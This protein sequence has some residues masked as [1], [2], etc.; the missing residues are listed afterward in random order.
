MTRSYKL[1]EWLRERNRLQAKARRRAI[2]RDETIRATYQG[3]TPIAKAAHEAGGV[4]IEVRLRLPLGEND[5]CGTPVPVVG[6]NGGKIPCGSL[7]TING[8]T[9][10]YYCG[11]CMTQHDDTSLDQSTPDLNR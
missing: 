9:R 3:N 10:P 4:L 6:T 8:E 7:L 1:P 5:G 11:Y 2:Q